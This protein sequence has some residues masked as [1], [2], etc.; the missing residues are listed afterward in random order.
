M[1]K[2]IICLFLVVAAGLSAKSITLTSKT[3]QVKIFATGE[4]KAYPCNVDI[5]VG[6]GVILIN[7]QEIQ[8]YDIVEVLPDLF[9]DGY[10]VLRYDCTNK[11]GLKCQIQFWTSNTKEQVV[12]VG[13]SDCMWEYWLK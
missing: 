3:L 7:S 2:I 4:E 12:R 13:F 8:L 5:T 6:S 11:D 9:K 1:K 10:K